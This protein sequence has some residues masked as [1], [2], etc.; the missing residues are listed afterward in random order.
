MRM[1]GKNLLSLRASPRPPAVLKKK[2]SA[3]PARGGRQGGREGRGGTGLGW[4]AA[5]IVGP[6]AC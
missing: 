6:R 5:M 3:T 2:V 1:R 4:A